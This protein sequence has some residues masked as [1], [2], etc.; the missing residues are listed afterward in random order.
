MRRLMTLSAGLV[1]LSGCDLT[2]LDTVLVKFVVPLLAL[3][4]WIA[5]TR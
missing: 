1:L 5:A 2:G 3:I 4:Q